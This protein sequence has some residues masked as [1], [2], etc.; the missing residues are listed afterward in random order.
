MRVWNLQNLLLALCICVRSAAG[1]IRV[2]GYEG[3]EVQVSCP[4]S[5]GYESYEKYLCKKNCGND[6]VLIKTT[7]PNKNK[8]SI[9]DDNQKRVFTATISDLS[10]T[11]AGRYWCGVTRNGKD[12]YTDVSLEVGHDTCCAQSTKVQSYEES[13]VSISCQYESEDQNLKYVCRGNQTS[14]CLEK[15]ILTSDNKQTGQF[16]LTDDKVSK[17]FTV[18]IT[19]LTQN[20]AGSYLCGVHGNTGL[21][22]FSAFE[23]EVK[24]WCCVRSSKLS[25]IVGR[26]VTMQ[27][28]YPPQHG[29][30]RKFL[31][32]GD[33]R[34]NCT[35]MVTR[36]SRFTLQDDVSSS[37]FLVIIT[38]LEAGDAGTYWCGSDS[39]WTV[40]NYTRIQLSASHS[41]AVVFIV[42]AVLLTLTFALVIVYKY[43]CNKVRGA[44]ANMN[45]NVI[46]ATETEEVM[47]GAD[48]YENQDKACSQQGTSKPQSAGQ[49]YD[50]VGDDQQESIYQNFTTTDDIYC[51]EMYNKANRR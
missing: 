48:I 33:H 42:P 14:T 16:R 6:D 1:L 29:D 51:N 19:G 39:Q 20:H 41:N 18:T 15:A 9:H 28:P 17:R 13:S 2:S 31:C 12:I 47:A 30:N 45:R 26:P 23:L 32:K 22:V 37:S 34:N 5:E 7:E 4:Y 25:G 8:Y 35:D 36:R 11:D 49:H 27:C 24:E 10:R 21:D 46:K 3:G 40:G 44:G 38:E 50:D 43:R